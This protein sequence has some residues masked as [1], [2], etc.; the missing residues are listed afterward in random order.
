[1]FQVLHSSAGAGKTHALVKHYIGLALNGPAHNGYAA[2]LALTFTNKAAAEMR[3]RIIDYLEGLAAGTDLSGA[4]LDVQQEVIRSAGI[5]ADELR[6]RAGNTLTHMLHHWPQLAV[7]TIDAFTRRVVMPFARDLRLDSDLRMTTEEQYYRDMAVERLLQEVGSDQALTQLLA[8]IC[9]DLI[10]QERAWRPDEPLRELSK[11]LSKEQALERL[12]QMRTITSEQLIAIRAELRERTARFRDRLRKLGREAQAAMQHE[13][14]TPSDL[15]SGSGGVASL[16]NKL[17]GF[18][19]WLDENRNAL[20]SLDQDKWHSAKASAGARSS[21]DRIAPILRH[22]V[23]TLHGLH[24]GREMKDHAIACAVQR[25]LLSSA[26]LHLLDERL[27]AVKREEGLAFFSDLTRKVA[28]IVQHEPAPFLYERLGEKYKHFLIDEFQDTSMLQ[29]HALLPL[30]T[31]SLSS[32]GSALLVGDA[33]QAIYRFR[34]GEAQQFVQLPRLFGRELMSAGEEHEA[35][36]LRNHTPKEPLEHNRRSAEVIVRFN[37]ALFDGLRHTLPEHHQ[38]VYDAPP[39]KHWRTMPGLVHLRCY[40]GEKPGEEEDTPEAP[41]FAVFAAEQARSDGFRPGDMAVLVRTKDQGRQVAS[42]LLEAGFDV[43]SPDGLSL[44]GD[45]TV[46]AIVA[47]LRWLCRPTPAHATVA[48]QFIAMRKGG[49]FA[50]DPFADVHPSDQLKAWARQHPT[51][52]RRKPLLALTHAI[53]DAFTM[54]LLNEVHTFVRDQGDAPLEFLDHWDRTASKRSVGGTTNDHAVRVMTVHASKGLQFPVVIVP[55]CEMNT[56]AKPDLLWI[57]THGIAD[58]LP[59]AVI[60]P[61]VL[62]ESAQLH[63]VIAEKQLTALD[64]MD[65][66]YV[67]FTRPEIRLYAG[68]NGKAK[69]GLNADLTV[70]LEL[71]LGEDKVIGARAPAPV[72]STDTTEGVWHLSPGLGQGR[73][74]PVLRL[75]APEDWDPADPDPH[76]SLGRAMHAVLARI[77]VPDDLPAALAEEAPRWGMRSAEQEELRARLRIIL[78]S[79]AVAPFFAPGLHVHAEADLIDANGQLH[80]PDRIVRDGSTLRVVDFKTG[81]HK[82]EHEQQVHN[83][84]GLLRTI[85]HPLVSAHLLYLREGVLIDVPA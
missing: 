59:T 50:V 26:A 45:A 13:G 78:E 74:R 28:T 39:Q 85:G 82:P 75:E 4:L 30:L 10:E 83:Y 48:S 41:A 5:D 31:N 14:I 24:E 61:S 71:D 54:G 79:P 20:R 35:I 84:A 68:V 3:E 22:M 32:G 25:D 33:K 55:W 49:A 37:N 40:T 76:R 58:P 43:V 29:W 2:I 46:G 15:A 38:R 64:H 36:M 70:Q 60:R 1:M 27:E 66:L 81:T 67:A 72:K 47:L 52:N 21:I 34:N 42:A 12:A 17:V 65:L 63:E 19:I 57:D 44:G 73:T 77:Q 18:D 53:A 23:S 9:T 62:L 56:R 80:R 6:R 7:T 8:A 51:L 16:I 11:Q 69:S